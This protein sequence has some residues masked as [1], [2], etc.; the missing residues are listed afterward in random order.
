MSCSVY[1]WELAGVQEP[2]FQ[3]FGL[4]SVSLASSAKFVSLEKCASSGKS[5]GSAVAA[6]GLA[7][8]LVV[9]W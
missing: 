9:G 5:V 1:E 8:P 6:E 2:H 7:M 4:F 3:E